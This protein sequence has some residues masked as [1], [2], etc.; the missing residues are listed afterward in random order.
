MESFCGFYKEQK[1][2]Y[3]LMGVQPK[4]HTK[5]INSYAAYQLRENKESLMG[6]SRR[7]ENKS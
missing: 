4:I 2:I 6:K 7:V 3:A 5:I 1:A